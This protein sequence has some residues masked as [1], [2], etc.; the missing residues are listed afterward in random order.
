MSIEGRSSIPEAR[1][2]VTFRDLARM[3]AVAPRI[4]TCVHL[5]ERRLLLGVVAQRPERSGDGAID[6]TYLSHLASRFAIVGPLW[7]A[8]AARIRA[9]APARIA[10]EIA[11]HARH[12]RVQNRILL[13]DACAIARLLAD[14]GVAHVFLKGTALLVRYPQALAAR[15]TDDIDLLVHARDVDLV[16]R[17]LVERGFV[18]RTEPYDERQHPLVL[19]SA[20]GTSIEVHVAVSELTDSIWARRE[21]ATFEGTTLTVPATSDLVAHLCHHVLFQHA[22]IPRYLPRHLIDLSALLD[23]GALAGAEASSHSARWVEA[24]IDILSLV[25]AWSTDRLRST[26]LAALMFPRHHSV[27]PIAIEKRL[28]G[29]FR[30]LRVEL[31][32]LERLKGYALFHAD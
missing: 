24:S 7:S 11:D 13:E 5:E 3:F 9:E 16:E 15:H 19:T 8:L 26:V 18:R 21:Q 20:F 31:R 10:A 12:V 27:L 22:A 14:E 23:A 28:K 17:L 25:R 6:W 4:P 29:G 2:G 1:A 32:A 30:G